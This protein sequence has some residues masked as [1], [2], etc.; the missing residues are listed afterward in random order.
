M[1]A[2]YLTIDTEYSSG[3]AARLG[4]HAREEVF[5]RSIDGHTREGAEI[6]R[7]HV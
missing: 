6:G 5:A 4:V 2:V 7:A 3:L 1:T